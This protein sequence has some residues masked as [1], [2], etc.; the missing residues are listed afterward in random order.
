MFWTPT[1]CRIGMA[2]AELRKQQSFK[3]RE[4]PNDDR[5]LVRKLELA[6][7]T[8]VNVQGIKFLIGV[9]YWSVLNIAKKVYSCLY[10]KKNLKE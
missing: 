1:K 6:K 3:F 2:A 8:F 10:L 9:T 5:V 4:L 7:K